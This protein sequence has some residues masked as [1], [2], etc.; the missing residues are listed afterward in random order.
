MDRFI[1]AAFEFRFSIF[2]SHI[3]D[4]RWIKGCCKQEKLSR[5]TWRDVATIFF[6]SDFYVFFCP[7]SGKI[8]MELEIYFF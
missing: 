5:R 1:I 4:C 8:F 3:V 6:L 2:V 7:K